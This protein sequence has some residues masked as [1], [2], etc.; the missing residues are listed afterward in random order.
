VTVPHDR[1]LAELIAA[2]VY[3]MM[4]DGTVPGL[5]LVVVGRDAIRFAGGYGFADVADRTPA[6]PETSYLWFSMSKIATATAAMRLFDEGRL[7]LDAPV[8]EYIAWRRDRPGAAPT[9]RQLLT[10]TGGLANPMPLRWVHAAEA[11]PVDQEAMLRRLLTS[12][13]VVGRPTAPRARYSNVGYLA[14]A[15]VIA[16][17]ARS[18]FERFL[19]T[20]I[21]EPA[22]MSATGF[23][24]DAGATAATGYVRIPRI[25][26]PL[27]RLVIPAAL[28]GPR[29]GRHRSLRPFYV[30]GAGY[31]GLVGPAI[32]AARLLRL[33]LGEGSIDGRRILSP[34]ATRSM[35]HITAR[36]RRLDHAIGW[37][38]QRVDGDDE[39]L[40]HF[41][42]GAGFWN[43]MRIYPRRGIGIVA[44]ANTTAP[45]RFQ[46]LFHHLARAGWSS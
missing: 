2:S 6:T 26:D 44:M 22:G 10:H 19:H 3:A 27:L 43:V 23:T 29:H 35:Q 8:T 32:D 7:D 16:A 9:M 46:A 20:S 17:A 14:A 11:P 39:Y 38:R 1:E 24:R 40:E 45:Y 28:L 15:Q 34:H 4:R 33:H 41:G 42:A 37:F 12:R 21:L 18:P 36:G 13:W 5:S 25:A 31:G 30:D